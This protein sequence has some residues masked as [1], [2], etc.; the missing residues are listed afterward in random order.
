MKKHFIA[1]AVAAAVTAPAFAQNV[2][3]GGVLDITAYSQGSLTVDPSQGAPGAVL[4]RAI[5]TTTTSN[6]LGAAGAFSTSVLNF[7]GTEDLGGGLKA[8]FFLNQSINSN[9][10]SLGNRDRFL[11]L[12][13]GFGGLKVGRFPAAADGYG[14]FAATGTVNT[15]GTSESGAFDLE[16]GTLGRTHALPGAAGTAGSGNAGLAAAAA[17]ANNGFGQAAADS[18]AFGRQNGVIEYTTPA[19]SGVT[20]TLTY[21]NNKVDRDGTDYLGAAT[22]KQ[23]GVRV[24]YSVGALTAAYSTSKRKVLAEQVAGTRL[25]VDA[26]G[27]NVFALDSFQSDIEG[28]MSWLGARYNLG[29]AT[30]FASIASREDTRSRSTVWNAALDARA[31]TVDIKVN[32][33]GVQVPLG[34]TMFFASMYDGKDG[35]AAGG[36]DDREIRGHQFGATYSLSKRTR[37]YAVFGE[38]ENNSSTPDAARANVTFKQTALGLVHQF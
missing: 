34:A 33:I 24:D 19:F 15:A 32:S 31:T 23:T 10:G 35:R 30:V 28:E 36:A 7:S 9:D 14:G 1:A 26:G 38:N 16:A 2:T 6:G 29:P 27:A 12:T 21:A 11:Q 22:A 18:G 20:A 4:G 8:S 37:A 13:G 5:K 25:G 3:V 17:I